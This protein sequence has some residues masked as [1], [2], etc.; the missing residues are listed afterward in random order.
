[1]SACLCVG[2]GGVERYSNNWQLLYHIGFD[3]G[4]IVSLS[5]LPNSLAQHMHTIGTFY[6][7]LGA[8]AG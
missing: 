5:V 4:D 8:G 6:A 2:R 3:F 1:M 7:N